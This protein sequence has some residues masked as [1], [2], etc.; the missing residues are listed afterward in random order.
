MIK[1]PCHPFALTM[2]SRNSSMVSEPVGRTK[3]TYE[4]EALAFIELGTSPTNTAHVVPK[5]Y[6]S[7]WLAF[8][9]ISS[10]DWSFLMNNSK[11]ESTVDSKLLR[12][13]YFLFTLAIASS[14]LA[15]CWN[16]SEKLK[17]LAYDA[18]LLMGPTQAKSW[19]LK[20]LQSFG[21]RSLPSYALA[22]QDETPAV[23]E[24]SARQIG[25]TE[26]EKYK[27][28]PALINAVSDEDF[29]VR[30]EVLGAL[31]SAKT[32]SVPIL[33]KTMR[34]EDRQKR[35]NAAMA[36]GEIRYGGEKAIPVLINALSDKDQ[37]VRLEAA[38]ALGQFRR[39]AKSAVPALI[40]LLSD[41]DHDVRAYAVVALGRIKENLTAVIPALAAIVEREGEHFVTRLIAAD[42]LGR[43]GNAS[44]P[45]LIRILDNDSAY[46]RALAIR[47][48]G[49]LGKASAPAAAKIAT[50]LKDEDFEVR[51]NAA[52]ALGQIGVHSSFIVQALTEALTDDDLAIAP[53]AE[54]ALDQLNKNRKP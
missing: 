1:K 2:R 4:Q 33:I 45:A 28:I 50:Q 42:T 5:R 21:E 17:I 54:D 15:L 46:A 14:L 30:G 52:K 12:F 38:K 47:T 27:I 8:V 34:S 26:G 29:S 20:E 43:M 35:V 16:H 51:Q 48:L 39:E 25:I 7:V 36:L 53:E 37:E 49:K 41:P 31:E 24:E 13:K 32:E 10:K 44:Q 23:R 40:D 9:F 11:P 19:S 22:L 6:Y 3:K 18:I